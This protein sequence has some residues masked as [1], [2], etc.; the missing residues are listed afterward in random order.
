MVSS[1]KK[2]PS[3]AVVLGRVST[4]D[5]DRVIEDQ[6]TPVYLEQLATDYLD[7]TVLDAEV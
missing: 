3:I 4:E 7:D 6:G 5:T 1:S 2:G